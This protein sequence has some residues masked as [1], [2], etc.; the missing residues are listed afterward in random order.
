MWGW[1]L[2]GFGVPATFASLLLFEVAWGSGGQSLIS[3]LPLLGA[4][5]NAVLG[6]SMVSS[7]AGR[8]RSD[9]S[10]SDRG[11]VAK[12][13]WGSVLLV[14]GVPA[15]LYS[16]P[17]LFLWLVAAP[18]DRALE[19]PPHLLPELAMSLFGLLVAGLGA[20]LLWSGARRRASAVYSMPRGRWAVALAAGLLTSVAVA[21]TW[22]FA[23][24]CWFSLVFSAMG[25][26]AE[27]QRLMYLVLGS[28]FAAPLVGAIIVLVEWVRRRQRSAPANE[29]QPYTS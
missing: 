5:V 11:R 3:L 26:E 17:W 4:I 14:L 7:G 13:V 10:P 22:L 16:L 15:M 8:W 27:E 25:T 20:W 6:A 9:G 1:I 2:L 19:V 28:L 29:S 23:S 21:A 18:P 12:F 24:L